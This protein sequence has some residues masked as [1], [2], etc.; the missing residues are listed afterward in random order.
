MPSCLVK[1]IYF[2]Y[3]YYIDIIWRVKIQTEKKN[4]IHN[5]FKEA[6]Y[7]QW[8]HVV[9]I[10]LFCK[11]NIS[12][13]HPDIYFSSGLFHDISTYNIYILI[14]HIL[15]H[16]NLHFTELEKLASV[17]IYSSNIYITILKFKSWKIIT[18]SAF[19]KSL[20]FINFFFNFSIIK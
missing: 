9:F 20:C 16:K 10:W 15:N 6:S 17:M 5:K 12:Y 2:I 4:K 7:K 18:P 1:Q 14:L 13:F 11:N 3:L 19:H 8:Q